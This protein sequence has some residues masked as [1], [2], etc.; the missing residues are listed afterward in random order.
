MDLFL[1][2]S[3][4]GLV[5]LVAHGRCCFGY[6]RRCAVWHRPIIGCQRAFVY[7]ADGRPLCL[8]DEFPPC[9]GEWSTHWVYTERG[10]DQLSPWY[11][12]QYHQIEKSIDREGLGDDHCPQASGYERSYLGIVAQK[13][14]VERMISTLCTLLHVLIHHGAYATV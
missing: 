1:L 4:T 8:S 10:I 9:L 3:A 14:S 5:R 7:P 12:C 6:I 2:C 11:R 13:E